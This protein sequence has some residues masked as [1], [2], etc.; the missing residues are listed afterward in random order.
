MTVVTFAVIVVT[1]IDCALETVRS[2]YVH[3][4]TFIFAFFITNTGVLVSP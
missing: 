4:T 2:K 1:T 3:H